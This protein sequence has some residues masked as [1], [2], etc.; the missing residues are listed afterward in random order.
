MLCDPQLPKTI[1]LCT[2]RQQQETLMQP[3]HCDLRSASTGPLLKVNFMEWVMRTQNRHPRAPAAPVPQMRF[4]PINVG[5]HF[6]WESRGFRSIQTSKRSNSIA[7]CKQGLRNHI[8]PAS[9]TAA[10][11]NMD[12]AWH[13][14]PPPG[15]DDVLLWWCIVGVMY[16]C[17]DAWLWWCVVVV[18]YGY[19]DVLLWWCIV[20][21]CYGDVLLLLWYCCSAV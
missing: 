16:S 18:M 14:H 12:A 13:W 2:Q 21:Y 8:T 15:C 1:V 20:M 9:T 11:I 5:N 17:G 4:P 3:F 6:A 10:I 7:I 19:G